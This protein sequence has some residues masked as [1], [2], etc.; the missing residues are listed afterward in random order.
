MVVPLVREVLAKEILP[1]M[2]TY[3]SLLLMLLGTFQIVCSQDLD[4]A[5]K[6]YLKNDVALISVEELQANYKDYLILDARAI[7]EYEV[8]KL[9]QSIWVG[10]EDFSAERLKQL[11][12]EKNKKIVVYCSIGVRSEEIARKI[13]E[14]FSVEIYNLYGGIF[15]WKNEG[16]NVVD[17]NNQPTNKV[18]GYSRKWG[19]YLI[20]AEVVYE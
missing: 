10:Y 13:N 1:K 12:L 19:S 5:L 16:F 2:K 6:R 11:S 18:H 9:D 14:D 15:L 17:K 3:L 7:E 4:D 20:Q 8:S